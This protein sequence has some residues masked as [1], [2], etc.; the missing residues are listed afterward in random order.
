MTRM[1]LGGA[2]A[3]A[4]LCFA[5]PALANC[6]LATSYELSVDENTVTVCPQ[7]FDARACPDPDGMLRQ[8]TDGMLVELSDFCEVAGQGGSGACYV[9]ECVPKG[10]YRY[11]FAKP[12]DCCASCCSTDYYA[13]VSVTSDLPSTC[14]LSP[15]NPGAQPSSGAAPWGTS[16]TICVYQ[17]IGGAPGGGGAGAGGTGAS[18]AGGTGASPAKRDDDDGGC[19]TRSFGGSARL[20]IVVDGI[21]VA[22]GLALLARRRRSS[23]G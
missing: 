16:P 19:A 21:F 6:A 12:Y 8:D 7:N 11:G 18:G 23:R 1:A 20:V 17:G 10:D 9:D 22:L 14:A 3:L 5:D 2:L 4:G 15:G 13:T